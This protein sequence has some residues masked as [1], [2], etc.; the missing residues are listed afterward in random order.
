MFIW[1][2]MISSPPHI[3]Y[4]DG[5]TQTNS[6]IFYFISKICLN[7]TSLNVSCLLTKKD[8]CEYKTRWLYQIRQDDILRALVFSMSLDS[9]YTYVY[10]GLD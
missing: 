1:P 9:I 4:K 5:F 10:C 2:E 7:Q 6:H 8:G 3:V